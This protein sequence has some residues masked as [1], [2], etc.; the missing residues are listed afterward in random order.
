MRGKEMGFFNLLGEIIGEAAQEG[1]KQFTSSL[2]EELRKQREEEYQQA[3][4][5]ANGIRDFLKEIYDALIEVKLEACKSGNIEE[6][7]IPSIRIAAFCGN[8]LELF[9]DVFPGDENDK[10]QFIETAEGW[11]SS[12]ELIDTMFSDF[13]EADE[14]Y[15]Q[16]TEINL[17]NACMA[18][19]KKIEL[20]YKN[21]QFFSEQ[22]IMKKNVEA[23]TVFTS[24]LYAE[25]NNI[26]ILLL[27]S[28]DEMMD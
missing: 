24:A 4:E 23:V 11:L 9:C 26:N 14:Q 8:D 15:E 1:M 27:E 20:L 12:V 16:Y 6:L 17:K 3:L 5:V 2:Q 28:Y 7:L 13:S 19:Y 22:D 21:V 18:F 25:I 10:E